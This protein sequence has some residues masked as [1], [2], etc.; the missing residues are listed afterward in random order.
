MTISHLRFGPK[1]IHAPYVIGN[2]DANFVACH[3]FTF[4]EQYDMLKYVKPGGIFLLNSIYGTDEVW[5]HLPIEV[6]NAIIEKK[7][8][9][10]IIDAYEV[11]RRPAWVPA[12]TPSCRP[13]SSPQQYSS[14]DEAIAEIKKYIKKT[15]SKRGEKVVNQNYAAVDSSLSI[16]TR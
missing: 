7:L 1:P 16:S 14:K 12:S 15:Y 6:Q 13:A 9:F 4:L 2:N 3:Q 10:F 5:D 8:R 11:A